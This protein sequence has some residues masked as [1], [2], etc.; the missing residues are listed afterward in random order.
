MEQWRRQGGLRDQV[1][2]GELKVKR[3]LGLKRFN[4][5]EYGVINPRAGAVP[6]QFRKFVSKLTPEEAA[7][8][9]HQELSDQYRKRFQ[10]DPLAIFDYA[11][12]DWWA[13][14]ADWVQNKLIYWREHGDSN[15]ILKF[16]RAYAGARGV[17]TQENL[18]EIIGR[19]QKAYKVMIS[20]RRK[21]AS[22]E[23][24]CKSTKLP[25]GL[26]ERN[27]RDIWE[28][29]DI[30]VGRYWKSK[31]IA[32]ARVIRWLDGMLVNLKRYAKS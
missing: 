11:R 2:R 7:R 23:A 17:R 14:R 27:A 3:I 1:S 13:P 10:S 26:G 31:T 29:Y 22:I 19:D 5:W 9:A 12:A 30:A 6:M 21:G 8:I 16:A 25:S 20:I 18:T 15:N 24:I 28:A 4:Y 32:P